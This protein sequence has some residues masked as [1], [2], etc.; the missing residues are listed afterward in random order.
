[1]KNE[2]YQLVSLTVVPDGESEEVEVRLKVP[3]KLPSSRVSLPGLTLIIIL[4]EDGSNCHIYLE[5]VLVDS[6]TNVAASTLSKLSTMLGWK[7]E[8][9]LV[10]RD[11][12]LTFGQRPFVRG[13]LDGYIIT[14][15]TE[16]RETPSPRT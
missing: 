4:A 15:T 2:G 5:G 7:Y 12:F 14:T 1:M 10:R 9:F 3:V 11:W 8:F 16:M 6:G 13:S